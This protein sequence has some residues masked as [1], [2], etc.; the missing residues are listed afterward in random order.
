MLGKISFGMPFL[1]T[2]YCVLLV[3]GVR[4]FNDFPIMRLYLPLPR[5]QVIGVE[6]AKLNP[7]Y[8]AGARKLITSAVIKKPNTRTTSSSS[9]AGAGN[10]RGNNNNR[11]KSSKNSGRGKVYSNPISSSSSSSSS[12]NGSDDS[13][14][15]MSDMNSVVSV[16]CGELV[17]CAGAFAAQV[18]AWCGDTVAPLPVAARRRTVFSVQSEPAEEAPCA[19]TTPLVVCPETGAYFR[20]DGATPGRFLCGV[21]PPKGWP[22][23]DDHSVSREKEKRKREQVSYCIQ[24]AVCTSQSK[25]LLSSAPAFVACC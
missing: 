1:K 12:S 14:D 22:D 16:G 13:D 20:P 18:V 6:T 5:L 4:L 17:N 11:S 7:E 9:S 2:V 24:N 25:C 8:N 3:V 21:S 19:T 15:N 10:A 23:P